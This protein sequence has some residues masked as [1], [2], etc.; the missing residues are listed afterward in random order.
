MQCIPISQAVA[1]MTLAQDVVKQDAAS[2]VLCGKGVPLTESLIRR[3]E[4]MGIKSIVIEGQ[5]LATEGEPSLDDLMA[6]L[7]FRFRRV[8]D[9]PLMRRVKEIYRRRIGNRSGVNCDR[10]AE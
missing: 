1:G 8:N 3:L 9:D 6:A 2:R 7:E 10:S 4:N 5:L